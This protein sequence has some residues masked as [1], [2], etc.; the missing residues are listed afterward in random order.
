MGLPMQAYGPRPLEWTTARPPVWVWVQ[1]PHEMAQRRRG[2]VKGHNDRV[3]V[4][5]VEG[6]G[7]GWEITVWRQAVTHRIDT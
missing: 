6:P 7:G 5:W 1:F 2:Y 3:C 4:V